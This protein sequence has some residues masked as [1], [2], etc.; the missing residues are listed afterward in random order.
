VG[1]VTPQ[2]QPGNPKPRVF[3]LAA[4]AAVI[5][6]LGFNSLG[7]AAMREKLLASRG[8][9]RARGVLGVNLG[10]NKDSADLMADYVTGVATLGPLADF[11]VVNV[12]SPNTPGLRD[13]QARGR[14]GQLVERVLKARAEVDRSAPLPVLFKVAPDLTAE[15]RRDVAEVALEHKVDGL[16]VGNTTLARP[17][18]LASRHRREQGGLSGAPLFGPST[19]LLRDIYT[20]TQGSIP[21]VGVGGVR[22]GAD[23]YAKI[24]AGAALVELY[25]G[26]IYNGPD[27]VRRI[28]SELSALLARDGIA[29]LADAVGLDAGRR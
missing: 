15:D 18:T 12:S 5:N 13:L 4:D 8:A 1:S 29:H 19:T 22:S 16:I 6:R 25:T 21:L 2:P 24:R 26:L 23:A 14:F 28:G 20:L 27:L 3:R 11:L 17:E 9:I 7:H 10:A